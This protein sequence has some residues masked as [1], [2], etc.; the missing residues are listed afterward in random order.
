MES[1]EAFVTAEAAALEKLLDEQE[2][3]ARQNVPAYP[4]RPDALRFTAA[5][6]GHVGGARRRVGPAPAHSPQGG[7]GR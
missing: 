6:A 1:L 4:Q 3:W 7:A 2:A 5:G